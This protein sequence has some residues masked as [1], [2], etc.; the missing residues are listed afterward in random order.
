ME[1]RGRRNHKE[2]FERE[3]RAHRP[4]DQTESMA[5]GTLLPW[6]TSHL[7]SV[8]LCVDSLKILDLASVA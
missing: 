4:Q 3:S 5:L 2:G 1:Q 6:L 8:D 7:W